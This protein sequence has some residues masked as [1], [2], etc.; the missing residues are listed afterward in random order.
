[1]ATVRR[2][3]FDHRIEG[4]K[5]GHARLFHLLEIIDKNFNIL[6]AIIRFSQGF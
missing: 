5:Q 4:F 2:T 1:M 3:L 6:H